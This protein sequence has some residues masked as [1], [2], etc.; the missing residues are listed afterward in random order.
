MAK[1]TYYVA[2]THSLLWHLYDVPRLGSRAEAAFRE[3]SAGRAT[4]LIPAIVLAEI[5]HT[6]ERRRHDIDID[7]AL[8]QIAEADNF[9]VLPFDLEAARALID[10]TGIPEMHDRMI[11]AA[12][13]DYDAPLIT[14]DETITASGLATVV[15]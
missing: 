4:L 8:D 10:L 1:P 15:W 2:D 7:E 13:R 12:A 9:R 5:V 3:V 11:V 6:V 14:R